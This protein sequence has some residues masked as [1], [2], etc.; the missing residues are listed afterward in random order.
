MNKNKFISQKIKI[1][2]LFY[3]KNVRV[4]TILQSSITPPLFMRCNLFSTSNP[5]N[6]DI[7]TN[8]SLDPISI[9]ILTN[10]FEF[11]WS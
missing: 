2:N 9:Q 6:S 10:N 1:K 8:L 11:N 4:I 3:K 5:T 7:F